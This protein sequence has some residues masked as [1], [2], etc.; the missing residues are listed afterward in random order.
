MVFELQP[1]L[2]CRGLTT[3]RT[4]LTYFTV[5]NENK[6]GSKCLMV[7]RVKPSPTRLPINSLYTPMDNTLLHSISSV[8]HPW[9]HAVVRW[10]M[11][12]F[13]IKPFSSVVEPLLD[14][15][16]SITPKVEQQMYIQKT[17]CGRIKTTR[18]IDV[19][20]LKPDSGQFGERIG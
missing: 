12:F 18:Y 20:S 5:L 3:M 7:L 10:R 6:E 2:V 16:V 13:Y 8:C 4:L 14:A 11:S 17:V 9:G 19:Y 1:I 15:S